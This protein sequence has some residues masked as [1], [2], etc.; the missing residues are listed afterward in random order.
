MG[1]FSGKKKDTSGG[2]KVIKNQVTLQFYRANVDTANMAGLVNSTNA[3]LNQLKQNK[4]IDSFTIDQNQQRGGEPA[5]V[6][7]VFTDSSRQNSVIAAMKKLE[8]EEP[9]QLA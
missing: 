8:F 2:A 6:V 9:E 5:V 1:F 3:A 4:Q 7:S